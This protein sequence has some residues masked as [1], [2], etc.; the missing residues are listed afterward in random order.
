VSLHRH[1]LCDS[2]GHVGRRWGRGDACDGE[3]RHCER[4]G[5]DPTIR[6]RQ[7]TGGNPVMFP[8]ALDAH[9]RRDFRS[10][11]AYLVDVKRSRFASRTR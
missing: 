9:P 5:G 4:N 7:E 8:P 2:H 11:I 1:L 3:R 6:E 10:V